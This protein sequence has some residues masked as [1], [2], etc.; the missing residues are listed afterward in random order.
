MRK[1]YVKKIFLTLLTL[2]TVVSCDKGNTTPDKKAESLS[3]RIDDQFKEGNYSVWHEGESLAVLFKGKRGVEVSSFVLEG[4]GGSSKGDFSSDTKVLSEPLISV[5]PSS[6]AQ[7]PS[8]EKGPFVWPRSQRYSADAVLDIPRWSSTN[9]L[10]S[11]LAFKNL[12][13]L[14]RVR[15]KGD[16]RVTCVKISAQEKMSGTFSLS[17]GGSEPEV[18]FSGSQSFN[19]IS[20]EC[21]NGVSLSSQ[22]RDFYFSLPEGNYSELKIEFLDKGTVSDSRTFDD[23][24]VIRR[25]ELTSLSVDGIKT[26]APGRFLGIIDEWTV[27]GDEVMDIITSLSL[28][29]EAS[30]MKNLMDGIFV[31][32]R[33]VSIEYATTGVDG[34]LVHA[35]GIIGYQTLSEGESYS[36]IVSIQHPS[37]DIDKAPSKV[38]MSEFMIPVSVDQNY[39]GSKYIAVM[40]DY[41]G[42]GISQTPDLQHPYLHSKLAGSTCAD[43]FAAA[44]EFIE[45]RG[46]PVA[47]A[48]GAGNKASFDLIGYS[49]GGAAT[50]STLLEMVDRG[51]SSR[52]NEVWAGA[53]PYNLRSF[54]DFFKGKRNFPS[55]QFIPFAFRGLC[56]GEGISFD[57]TK[58]FNEKIHPETLE[59]MLSTSQASS[60][61]EKIGTNMREILHLDFYKEEFGGNGEI[62]KIVAVSDKNSVSSM[63][64]PPKE[65]VAKIKLYHSRN[66]DVVPY[67]CSE[68]LRDAWG[69]S[70]IIDL[71]TET[72]VSGAI[73]FL[74]IYSGIKLL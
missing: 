13:G 10:K 72:H 34:S 49:Q 1:G 67:A 39:S 50:I 53:G 61:V 15:V 42:Y 66:D 25:N 2:G 8:D 63:P 43:M 64:V 74:K 58:V 27:T 6:M 30:A 18:S 73:K 26:L 17:F 46:L 60:W 59:Q 40:A 5:S 69:C 41:L 48:G 11:V 20:L 32:V 33:I 65:I 47:S 3:A 7:S 31:P 29:D 68:E 52:I 24:I 23:D 19:E 54:L 62:L 4:A 21:G 56:Y 22:G 44:E 45:E 9:G 14:L 38:R 36:R 37:L 51:W 57:Y 12:G 35:S 55:P 71:E 70:E 28:P 16:G